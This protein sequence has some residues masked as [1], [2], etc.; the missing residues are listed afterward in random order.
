MALVSCLRLQRPELPC[1]DVGTAKKPVLLPMELVSVAK[2]QRQKLVPNEAQ[3]N[4]MLKMATM[5]PQ[6]HLQSVRRSLQATGIPGEPRLAAFQLSVSDQPVQVRAGVGAYNRDVLAGQQ[7]VRV[8]ALVRLAA[9]SSRL[10]Q[11]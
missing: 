11:C 3:R 7:E 9:L 6:Q 5:P 10:F 4:E 8:H 1:V 2:G